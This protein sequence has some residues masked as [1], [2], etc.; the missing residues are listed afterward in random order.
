MNHDRD[1]HIHPDQ[2]YAEVPQVVEEHFVSNSTVWR[3]EERFVAVPRWELQEKEKVWIDQILQS[4]STAQSRDMGATCKHVVALI[5]N[6]LKQ[7]R[8]ISLAG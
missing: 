6:V 2:E 1:H 4:G 5:G 7:V 8:S 3:L